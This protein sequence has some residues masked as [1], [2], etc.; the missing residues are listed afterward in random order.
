[1]QLLEL[2]AS[3]VSAR[4]EKLVD[5]AILMLVFSA[6]LV[7]IATLQP[8]AHRLKVPASV[9]LAA[10]GVAVGAGSSFLLLTPLTDTLN[11]VVRPIV[12]LP[13][14]SSTFIYVFLPLLLFQTSL[15]IDVRR[16]MEDAAPILL[17]AVVAVVVATAVIGISLQW[18]FAIPI[19]VGLLLGSIVAT[20][21]P[22]AVVAIFREIGAPARLTRLVEGESLL[23]DAAA[24]ALFSLLYAIL[25]AGGELDAGEAA[26][27][28][29][30]MFVG[31][32]A[33][34]LAAGKVLVKALPLLGGLRAAEATLTLAAPYLVFIVGDQI[35]GVSGV[36]AVVVLG[37]VL[38]ASG[39][40]CLSPKNWRHLKN[41]WD[42]IG[43]WANSLVFILAAL[44]MPRLLGNLSLNEILMVLAVVVAAIIARALVLYLMLP[45]LSALRLAEKISPAYTVTILWGGLR[46]AV[47]VALALAVTESNALPAETKRF[48]G[49]AATGF[50]LFTLF[51][52]GTTLRWFIRQLGLDKLSPM[53]QL[54]RDQVLALALA[55]V[56]DSV[57]D[58]GRRYE[59]APTAI[60]PIAARY[61]ERVQATSATADAGAEMTDRDR[62]VVA[63]IALANRE[64]ELVLEHHGQGSASQ[65]VV[66]H[67]LR[68]TEKL[69]EGARAGGRS[70]YSSAARKLVKFSRTF[71]LA[72]ELHRRCRID[73]LLSR[74]LTERFEVLLIER[75][76]LQE[77][78]EFVGIR[79][80]PLFGVRIAE[81]L[82]DILQGRV[83]HASTALEAMRLQY[84]DYAEALERRFLRQFAFRMEIAH[85]DALRKEGLLNN[86]LHDNLK[87]GV[88]AHERYGE[89][90][91]RLDLKLNTR[92]LA[93][94]LPL[95]EGLGDAEMD[96]V[97]RL[98][99]P[100]FSVP[101][102]F[103]L[104][105]GERGTGVYFISTG[106]VEVRL[107]NQSIRLGRGDFF[108]EMALLGRRRR[109]AD[110]VALTYCHILVLDASDFKSFL[111][112][113]A[114]VREHVNAVVR[115][116]REMNNPPGDTR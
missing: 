108:G 110:V 34:G 65:P 54:L 61:D 99:R 8:V 4:G 60:R 13:V 82:T 49:V 97:I 101:G 78:M 52:N 86:E 75:L 63:L 33:L 16:M 87:R 68:H 9:L 47:T 94:Q 10:V 50:V 26:S 113:N 98:F 103:I 56:R 36:V 37:L 31:G 71:R 24:I 77:L 73:G 40:S 58:V 83:S 85:Y 89:D 92:D 79:L 17:L 20:T 100:R 115:K 104:K 116:R 62:L 42:Q 43:Y 105:K 76:I 57:K 64:R 35:A 3:T 90:K 7:V 74:R 69:T 2:L 66:E 1:M 96:A 114:A 5:V 109:I 30:F 38:S 111:N 81:I 55:D 15:T 39:R 112:T 70:G 23:N 45:A 11:D 80:K 41:V 106:A 29:L 67:L 22:A 59:L 51:I 44:L 6:L 88:V 12:D 32:A 95:M 46:G 27:R 18:L 91:P 53:D 48:V 84:P 25:T 21:D 19:L 28:F 93:T 107:P 14:K 102:E 72:H